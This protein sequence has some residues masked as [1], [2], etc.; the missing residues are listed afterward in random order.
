[1]ELGAASITNIQ[2]SYFA[3]YVNAID[4]ALRVQKTKALFN[5]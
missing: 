5:T 3:G 1:M 4:W 2:I